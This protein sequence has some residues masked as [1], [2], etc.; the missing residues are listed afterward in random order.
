MTG[1]PWGAAV[2]SLLAWYRRH[3]RDLPWRRTRDPYAVWV[4]EV[5]LQQ[6]RVETVIPYYERF[7]ARFPD[8][9]RLA[10][11]DSGD[12]LKLWEGLGYYR[13]ALFLLDGARWIVARGGWPRTAEGLLE[14]PGVGRYTA[15][16][17]ASIAFSEVAPIL[18]GNIKRVWARVFSRG[19]IRSAKAQEELWGFSSEAVQRGPASDVN[20]ALMELGATVCKPRKPGCSTCP[21]GEWCASKADGLA[22]ARPSPQRKSPLPSYEV[23]V[24]ILWHGGRFMVQR[25]PEAGL[26]AGLWELPGGKF[27]MGETARAAV[28]RELLEEVGVRVRVGDALPPVKHVYSHFRVRLHPF[29]CTLAPGQG[30]PRP[31]PGR[32]WITPGEVGSLAFPAA[33]L[34]IFRGAFAE[35]FPETKAAESPGTY[36]PSGSRRSR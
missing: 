4:S 32:R 14:V 36:R 26:L 34:R 28:A 8:V 29:H 15:G 2:T 31:L 3:R 11:A 6:T 35:G 33:T 27:E 19:D 22:H 25:R 16:A 7:L 1:F 18:D 21:L 23:A 10:S 12:I 30:V 5:M 13:R 24:G 20:Q 9:E 17:V